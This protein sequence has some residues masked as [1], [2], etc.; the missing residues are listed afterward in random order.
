MPGGDE[1]QRGV[2]RAQAADVDHPG[3]AA[4]VDEKVAGDQVAVGH[5]VAA[6]AGQ[7]AERRPQ[8]P[9]RRHVE[10]TLAVLQAR[11][12]PG[13]VVRQ[14]PAAVV[15]GERPAAGVDGAHAVNELR[16]VVGERL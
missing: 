16:E 7:L 4:A 3:Q 14:V 13:V 12:H 15:A 8:A 10:Q 6:L 11:L 9:Q 2:G 5:H 1:V